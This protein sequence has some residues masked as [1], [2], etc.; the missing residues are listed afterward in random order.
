MKTSLDQIDKHLPAIKQKELDK[1]RETI[2]S[3]LG[4]DNHRYVLEK[5]I[6]YGSY[7]RGNWVE[8]G[9]VKDGTTYEYKSDF[10]ILVVTRQGISETAWLGLCIDEN[11]DKNPGI[12]TEV[13]IIHHGIDFLNRKIEE[14][15]YFFVDIAAEGVLL[16]DTGKHQLS[17]P[18]LMTP[19]AQGQKAQ[20]DF[21]YWFRKADEF[22]EFFELA[23]QRSRHSTAAF[24]LHQATEA[25]YTA[26][27]L[28]HTDY[29][30]RGHNLKYL[31][32]Q[33]NSINERFREVF[34]MRNKKE[35]ELF[36]L[37][38][39][40]YVDSRYRKDYAITVEELNYLSERV[41]LLRK[42]TEE[43]CQ[44]EIA[45]LQGLQ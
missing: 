9:Y 23:V 37:L 5:I 27:L 8:D 45:R 16:H 12:K 6:L 44:K 25:Y 7:A 31:S 21:D 43:L 42:L 41:V 22:Y 34:P 14:N 36:Q 10:D 30:P 19:A 38:K 32:K 13:N 3:K 20:E 28:V 39:K 2:V 33:A 4:A 29:K 1:V 35:K 15:Y 26:I 18:G 11:I 40:A 24:L 17:T